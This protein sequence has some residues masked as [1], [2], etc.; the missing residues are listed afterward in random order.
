[1]DNLSMQPLHDLSS[2]Y[3]PG[4]NS[5]TSE[6]SADLLMA[7][8]AQLLPDGGLPGSTEEDRLVNSLVL[9]AAFLA[10]GHTAHTGAFRLHVRQLAN[11]LTAQVQARASNEFAPAV[12]ALVDRTEAGGALPGDWLERALTL[13]TTPAAGPIPERFRAAWGEWCRE[14]GL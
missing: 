11:F 3:V 1:M 8:A 14:G 9:L 7:L 6:T 2:A 12:R 4:G 5:A 13:L 10:A